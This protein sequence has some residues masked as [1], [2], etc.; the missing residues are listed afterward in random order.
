MIKI[1]IDRVV[2][3]ASIANVA[4]GHVGNA[5]NAVAG[6]RWQVDGRIRG[7]RNIDARLNNIYNELNQ[8]EAKIHAIRNFTYYAADRYATNERY[9]R[10]RSPLGING[11]RSI[12]G[13]FFG[14][15]LVYLYYKIFGRRGYQ[16]RIVSAFTMLTAR[17]LKDYRAVTRFVTTGALS[18]PLAGFAVLTGL[19]KLRKAVLSTVAGV[20]TGAN[21]LVNAGINDV[22]D[23]T[24]KWQKEI[25]KT[26]NATV[27]GALGVMALGIG[28]LAGLAGFSKSKP[29]SETEK[30]G[31]KETPAKSAA[32]VEPPAEEPL[33]HNPN[34]N[35][36]VESRGT[37][38]IPFVTNAGGKR[39]AASYNDVMKQFDVENN[40][41]YTPGDGKTWCNIYAWDVTKA[42][43]CEIPHYVNS[44]SGAP[45]S[46]QEALANPGT[47]LEQN[48]DRHYDWL[49]EHGTQYGW[50]EITADQA[51]QSAALGKPAV[52][53]TRGHIAMI[54]PNNA[55]DEGVHIS[56]AGASNKNYIP[57][58]NGFG[59]QTGGLKYYAH[60]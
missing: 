16:G 55:G 29:K 20:V 21:N 26:Y 14:I 19:V 7:R 5:K 36:N 30:A 60:D 17:W 48:C 22:R 4:R 53:V 11:R 37:E 39:S 8:I 46:Q 57:I 28:A 40:S 6:V 3:C 27:T 58:S 18:F 54:A 31:A 44:D 10:S 42:M 52:A 24:T 12:F 32:K 56:Q 38:V 43:G 13:M 47:Y 15:D 51:V 41:R 49:A 25:G 1:N 50:R 9:I 35:V 34:G 59:S 33:T 2:G 45:M 23:L